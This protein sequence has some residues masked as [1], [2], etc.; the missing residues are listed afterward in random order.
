L[1]DLSVP[2]TFF[3]VDDFLSLSAEEKAEKLKQWKMNYTLLPLNEFLAF[4]TDEQV[5]QLKKWKM[6]YTLKE[7]QEA[8]GFKS[9]AQYYLLLKKLR[10]Y[11]RVVNRFDKYFPSGSRFSVHEKSRP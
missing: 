3:S 9:S 1:E 6:N 11:D 8:W 5:E 10:I 7:I 2:R 4:S